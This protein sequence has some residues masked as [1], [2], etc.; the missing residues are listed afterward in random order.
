MTSAARSATG[1][2]ARSLPVRIRRALWRH[3]KALRQRLRPRPLAQHVFVA[4]MQRSGTNLLMD[5]LDASA[6]TQVFHE[7]DPRAFERYEM[8]DTAVIRKLAQSC[9]APIFVIKA[10]CELD[11]IRALMEGFNP[12][13]TL[14][15]VR[16]WRDSAASATKSFGNFVPQWRRLADGDASDWR[17]RGMSA[18]TRELLAALYRDDAT[19]AEGAAIM[20]FYRNELFF[21]QR[22]AADPRVRLVFYE[23]LVQQPAREVAAVY[24]FLGL[25]KPDAAVVGR[26]HARSVRHRVPEGVSPAV[27]DLCDDLLSRFR[28]LARGGAR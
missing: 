8:R 23:D 16:D 24:E 11:R 18:A 12:A 19:E 4:G 5:V 22:L 20:W 7:T 26:I 10:L 2:D 28:A 3:G 25:A 6:V 1:H 13:R 15:M 14:W 17:G 21:E 27:A 9:P